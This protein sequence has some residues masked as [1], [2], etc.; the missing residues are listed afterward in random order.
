MCLCCLFVVKLLYLTFQFP[1]FT[2]ISEALE[3][4]FVNSKTYNVG[5]I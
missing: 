5:N 1:S 2:S 3:E 4:F